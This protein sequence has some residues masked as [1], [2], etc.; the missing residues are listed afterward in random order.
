MPFF[1]TVGLYT[2]CKGAA[3]RGLDRDVQAMACA[4]QSEKRGT[5]MIKPWYRVAIT[6]IATVLI[7]A[8]AG[9][10]R[11]LESHGFFTSVLPGFAGKCR[12]VASATGPEDIAI[13]ARAKIA[14]LSATDRPARSAQKPSAGDGLYSYDYT[15]PGAV[16]VKLAG[17]P[18]DFHPHGIS[19]V[20][21]P[22]GRL[23]LLAINHRLDGTNTIDVFSVAYADGKAILTE[24]GNI[25]SGLL[26]SPNDLAAV[27]AD[28]FY[29]VNDH[30]SKSKTGR[31]LDDNLVLPRTNILYFDGSKFVPVIK[32]VNFP[33]GA[34]L[35]K[36]SRFLYVSES[37]ARTLLTFSRDPMSGRLEQV[38]QLK[39]PTNLDN[40]D[41]DAEGNVWVGSHPKA[42]ATAA[43]RSD[44]SKPAPSVIYKVTVKDGIPTGYSQV[45]ADLG[46]GIGASSV[47][48]TDGKTL[49]IGSALDKKILNCTLP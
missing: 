5:K 44:P 49:L 30:L 42:F 29:V 6:L 27:D 19:L 18:A 22:D 32:G 7:L 35:S 33:N 43:F 9:A 45:Y 36:D 15:K 39:I 46:P 31:W 21:S 8:L 10:W 11:I 2:L 17:V 20:R 4:R 1:M 16:P 38:G 13:D 34:M 40:V 12:A 41:L 23:T 24:T 37:Y 47:G 26:V 48:A 14:F 28:H 3:Y 25:G